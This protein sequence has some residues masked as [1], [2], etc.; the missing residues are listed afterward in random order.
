MSEAEL[1][2]TIYASRGED[3]SRDPNPQLVAEAADLTP[4][5]A[6]EIGCAEGADAAWLAARGWRV[7]AVDISGVA[8]NR[9]RNATPEF[10]GRIEWLCADLLQWVPPVAAYD[11]VTSHFVHFLPPD[12][13]VA[14]GRLAGAVRQH[15]TLLIVAHDPSDL[16]TTVK[17]WPV[18]DAYAT[19]QQLAAMLVPDD[20][21]IVVAEARPREVTDQDG[22][23][24]TVHD[25]IVKARRRPDRSRPILADRPR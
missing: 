18:P 9:A 19:A 5:R 21:D 23:P 1:W 17:R 20:W 12:R 25:V 24:V 15:G 14:I 22:N 11:L 4:G 2:D 7:T 3:P 8:L 10:A 6:L 13:D 16:Q